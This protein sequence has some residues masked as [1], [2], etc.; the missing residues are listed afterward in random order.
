[1]PLIYTEALEYKTSMFCTALSH[2]PLGNSWNSVQAKIMQLAAMFELFHSP[3]CFHPET[4]LGL[5]IWSK[6]SLN[7]PNCT[8]GCRLGSCTTLGLH[9]VYPAH[10][11]SHNWTALG[12]ACSGESLQRAQNVFLFWKG[13]NVCELPSQ[14]PTMVSARVFSYW[15]VQTRWTAPHQWGLG[16]NE[17][18]VGFPANIPASMLELSNFVLS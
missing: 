5:E 7:P 11:K 16:T 1:M 12:H 2:E 10:H 18:E 17:V 8:S 13:H 4:L 15:K 6:R 3:H 9:H 14:C